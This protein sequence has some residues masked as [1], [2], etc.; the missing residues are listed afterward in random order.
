[1]KIAV[2]Q[3]NF[4]VGNFEGNLQKMLAAVKTAKKQKADLVCFS[5]LATTAYPPRDFVE[6]DDF[7]KRHEGKF[8]H[9]QAWIHSVDAPKYPYKIDEQLAARGKLVFNNNCAECHGT[10]EN[11]TIAYPERV[12]PLEDI[13]TDPVRLRELKPEHHRQLAESWLTRKDDGSGEH[14]EVVIDP[15]GY[16]APPLKGIWASA[17]YLHN[18]SVPTLW[19]LLHPEQRP[20]IWKR[21]NR[22]Y[23]TENLGHSVETFE[24]LPADFESLNKYE[25]RRFYNH[26][27]FGKRTDGHDYPS[28]LSEEERRWK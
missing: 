24:T 22:E 14:Y 1:M 17:P 8:R 6:F 3:L 27:D 23:D 12:I 21:T 20:K 11:E 13:G 18:G 9:I 25:R 15:V 19:H 26:K 7:V 10:Y 28:A 5:E 2:A 4:H 16:L